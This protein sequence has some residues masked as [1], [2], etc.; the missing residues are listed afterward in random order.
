[1]VIG[2]TVCDVDCPYTGLF[3][4]LGLFPYLSFLHVLDFS[5]P[6]FFISWFLYS[7]LLHGFL[8]GVILGLPYPDLFPYPGLFLYIGLFNFPGLFTYPII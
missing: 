6:I 3:T 5:Y 4:Y 8:Q 1:M 2:Y 7:D